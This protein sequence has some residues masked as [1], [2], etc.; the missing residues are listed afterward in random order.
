[1][2]NIKRFKQ[3]AFN[4]NDIT[5][6]SSIKIPGFNFQYVTTNKK[7][8]FE[9]FKNEPRREV[10]VRH[11]LDELLQF[12][13]KRSFIELMQNRKNGLGG[14]ET[15][16][17]SELRFKPSGI[18]LTEDTKISSIR[19]GNADAYWLIARWEEPIL[20]VYG[21]DFD[22]NAYDHGS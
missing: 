5:K 14:Y 3:S 7:Y 22:H 18:A 13:S 2:P 8:N 16:Y 15:I 11:Q 4:K 10:D 9:K 19:F 20:Y 21:Y 6:N 12:I 1:M 17:S